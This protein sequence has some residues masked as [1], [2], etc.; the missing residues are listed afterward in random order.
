MNATIRIADEHFIEAI[1]AVASEFPD[2]IYP[3]L[4]GVQ[5]PC[6]YHR[7]DAAK[8]CLIGEALMR[9]DVPEDDLTA[10]R[11]AADDV[12]SHYGLSPRVCAAGDRAQLAQD[13]GNSWSEAIEAF[14]A[15]FDNWPESFR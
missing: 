11:G 3:A 2:Y 13:G 10:M 7:R 12:L 9:C 5:Q 8:G 1:R 6:V 15:E 4:K 14:N